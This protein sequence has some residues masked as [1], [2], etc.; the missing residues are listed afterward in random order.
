MNNG[1]EKAKMATKKKHSCSD[2]FFRENMHSF[3]AKYVHV[4]AADRS[5]TAPYF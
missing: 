2:I 1:N 5:E 3:H 4:I